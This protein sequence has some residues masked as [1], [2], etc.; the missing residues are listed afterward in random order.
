[1]Y[2][3]LMTRIDE[4]IVANQTEICCKQCKRSSAFEDELQYVMGF[5]AV[6]EKTE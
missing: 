5:S 1:M 3:E 2:T 6:D 4:L